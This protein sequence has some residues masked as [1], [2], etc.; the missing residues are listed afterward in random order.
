[1]ISSHILPPSNVVARPAPRA[2]VASLAGFAGAA[3]VLAVLSVIVGIDAVIAAIG[4]ADTGYV[5]LVGAAILTWLCFRG[6]TL[7]AVLAAI[8]TELT[9]SD[10]ILV[11]AGASFA[12]HVTPFGQ[13]GGE[14]VVALLV[15]DISDTDF[16]HALAAMA[17]FDL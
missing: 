11:N 16:E 12:T 10:A 7:R 14:P 13:A 2:I 9:L 3:I 17:S 6:V 4:R 8:G 1:M 5:A 15:S